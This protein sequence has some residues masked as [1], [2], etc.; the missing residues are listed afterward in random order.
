MRIAIPVG[1]LVLFIVSVF[2]FSQL[3]KSSKVVPVP[4]AD[5]AVSQIHVTGDPDDVA[6]A[7]VEAAEAEQ[8][9]VLSEE[10]ESAAISEDSAEVGSL[11]GVFSES[12]F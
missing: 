8:N 10:A 6:G 9:A 2:I 7:V 12:D 11:E 1:I 4:S 3:G 5:V